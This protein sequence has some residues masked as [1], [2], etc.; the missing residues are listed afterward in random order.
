M[1]ILIGLSLST[2][3]FLASCNLNQAANSEYEYA[4]KKL[5]NEVMDIHDAVMP[6]MSEL[7]KLKRQMKSELKDDANSA[8][9]D[10]LQQFVYQIDEASEAMM[11]WMGEFKKPDYSNFEAAKAVYA[12][13]KVKITNVREKMLSTISSAKAF[14]SRL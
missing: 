13:E 4:L 10:S 8:K 3:F 11:N 5:D 7:A 9:A 14:L 1:K 2:L 6:R 12:Q